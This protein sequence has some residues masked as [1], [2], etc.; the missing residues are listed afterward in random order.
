MDSNPIQPTT[1][2]NNNLNGHNYKD[3]PI[4][5]L[6]IDKYRK[7]TDEELTAEIIKKK[8]YHKNWYR[9]NKEKTMKKYYYENNTPEIAELKY[10]L[11]ELKQKESQKN[12]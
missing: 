5:N 8:E 7:K 10:K 11:F 4:I 3:D 2:K 12:L 9:I 6:L 1:D